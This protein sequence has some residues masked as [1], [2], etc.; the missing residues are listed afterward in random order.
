[1][2]QD[3]PVEILDEV[4][5]LEERLAILRDRHGLPPKGTPMDPSL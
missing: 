2:D 1:M 5:H 4:Q 3:V